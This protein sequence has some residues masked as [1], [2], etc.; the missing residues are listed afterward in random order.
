[1]IQNNLEIKGIT[2]DGLETKLTQ[3]ADDTTLTLDGSQHSL[4]LALNTLEVFG[5]ISGLKMNK[6]KTK[7]IWIGRKKFTKEK[8]NVPTKLEWGHSSFN[9]LGIEFSTNLISMPEKNYKKAIEK[10]KVLINKWKNRYLTPLGRITVI[11]THL[12]SQ[13]IHLISTLPRSES[14]LKELNNIL[15]QFLWNGKPDKIKR[16]T[17]NLSLNQGGMKMI[18]LFNFEKALKVNW[19]KRLISQPNSQWCKLLTTLNK[20]ITRI[21]Y[22]GDQWIHKIIHKID[23]TFWRNVLQD[24]QTLIQIQQKSK[25]NQLHRQ[26][27]WY[28]SEISKEP[29]FYPDW[30]KKGIHLI[31]DIFDNGQIMSKENINKKFGI[32]I[33]LMNYY[34]VKKKIALFISKQR[35]DIHNQPIERPTYPTHLD[36]I[37]SLKKGCR[38]FYEN[39]NSQQIQN[40]K[41]ACETIW[42]NLIRN[43]DINTQNDEKWK[44]VYKVCFYS[45]NDNDVIWLQYRILYKILGTKS[46]LKKLKISSNNICSLCN[47]SEETIEHLFSSCTET[48][49]LWNDIQNWINHRISVNL[50][51]TSQM[52]ILGYLKNDQHFWPLNFIIMTTKKYIFYSTKKSKILCITTLQQEVKKHYLEQKTIYRKNLQIEEFTKKWMIWKNIFQGL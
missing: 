1:M 8:L 42:M 10:V 48:T 44:Q 34:T 19:V 14:F 50:T 35:L 47:S 22:F 11:K 37:F 21:F 32:N 3:F 43:A 25:N 33:N 45:I 13:C 15:Y 4:Q 20:S 30:Y 49:Q 36:P 29:L 40:E 9:L 31:A 24:W 5:S 23:N 16:T 18:N 26:C 12:I 2:I 46:Y 51:L 27:I 38:K 7:V 52:K 17:I 28:N 39:F 6:E 41:P